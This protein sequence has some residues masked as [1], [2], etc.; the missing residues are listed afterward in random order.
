MINRNL[1]PLVVAVAMANAGVMAPA[2][3]Q[4][5]GP[6]VADNTVLEEVVVTGIRQSLAA[7]AD[8]KRDSQGVVDAITA[9]DMGK[10]PDSNLAESL[11]RI[12]GVSIDRQGGEGSRVTVRGFGGDFNMVTLNGRQMPTANLEINSA[13]AKR[14]FDF[15]TLSSDSITAVEVYKTGKANLLSGGIGSTINIQTMRPL[16]KPGLTASLSGNALMDTT[17]E[18]GDDVTPEFSGIY[19][20][21][22]FDDTVGIAVSGSYSER[23]YRSVIGQTPNGWNTAIADGTEFPGFINAP[24]AGEVYGIGQNF[25]YTTEDVERDRTNYQLTLQWQPIESVRATLDYTYSELEYEVSKQEMSVWF[26]GA[27]AVSGE[28]AG[29][30]GGVY[31]PL[32]YSDSTG[33]DIQLFSSDYGTTN[34]TDS[35]GFNIEWSPTES[36]TLAFD[37][38]DSTAEGKPKDDRG[39][40][41]AAPAQ[42]AQR[43][44]T[45]IS[46]RPDF[47]SMSVETFDGTVPGP[48]SLVG[49]GI[50]FRNSYQK[51]DIEQ[52]RF[53]GVFELDEEPFGLRT[54]DFGLNYSEIDNRSAFAAS[55]GGDWSGDSYVSSGNATDGDIDEI[56]DDANYRIQNLRSDFNE[57]NSD[58]NAW[59]YNVNFNGHTRDLR[60]FYDSTGTQDNLWANCKPGKLCAPSGY[61]TDRQMHE[62]Q[63]AAYIQT[64][65]H[66]EPNDMPVNLTLGLRYDDT[67]VDA[68]S[69]APNYTSLL[70]QTPNEL[71]LQAEGE[72]TYLEG[73]GSYDYWL[74]NV[75]FDIEVIEGVILRVSYSETITRGN[76]ED[77]QAGGS[78]GS[79]ARTD[80]ISGGTGGDPDLDPFESTNWDFSAEWYYAEG[81]YVSVGYYNKQVDN[82]IGSSVIN[83][84]LYPSLVQPVSG[85]RYAEALANI[86]N[87]GDQSQVLN[88]YREQ[89]WVDAGTGELL[90]GLDTYDPLDFTLTVPVNAEDAEIDGFEIAVQHMFGDSGFGFIANYTT[91]DGDVEYDNKTIGE[92]Q[93]ALLGLSDSYNIIGFYDKYGF[94]ARLAYNWRDEFLDATVQ[95]NKQEPIYVEDYGQWDLSVSYAM[96]DDRLTIF[97]E[98]INLTEEDTRK[99]G[100][101]DQMLWS[102]TEGGARYALGLRYTF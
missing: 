86:E 37:Y 94:Q 67:D 25:N 40:N 91:V 49:S 76:Y 99:H 69:L 36:L 57:V 23:D 6:A 98:A 55:N 54:I 30:P 33:R 71:Q 20:N 64:H 19:S 72:G 8:I 16:D 10:F 24:G 68:K 17:N 4:T 66:F 97:G 41:N 89:G 81:S 51:T 73:E 53:D 65:F 63:T 60:A 12:T 28:W 32:L 39:S 2:F 80:T 5:S 48:E 96:M 84:V 88:Y 95:D 79:Q 93:F 43:A 100:R 92:D 1:K 75:D 42:A 26:I 34:E 74:P 58:A 77:L 44:L 22:F 14:A 78:V 70:W 35:T 31:A 87:A 52:Y 101:T 45:T 59:N 9:E 83:T 102:A 61:T 38:H 82:F 11:Q 46:Y 47:P 18:E 29:S 50:S 27:N 62:E 15:A 90:N 13:S 21:T 7:S 3:A 56:F 85:P